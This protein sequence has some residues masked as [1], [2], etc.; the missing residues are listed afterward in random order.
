M[1]IP[2]GRER[3]LRGLFAMHHRTGAV[4]EKVAFIVVGF[5]ILDWRSLKKLAEWGY[6]CPAK[7]QTGGTFTVVAEE[8]IDLYLRTVYWGGHTDVYDGLAF[9]SFGDH[10][11]QAQTTSERQ[12]NTRLRPRRD[13]AG[14]LQVF[15]GRSRFD[16]DCLHVEEEPLL[17]DP[18]SRYSCLLLSSTPAPTRTADANAAR[19]TFHP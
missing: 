16:S 18:P 5:V 13:K 4:L 2:P 11:C 10:A 19:A 15:L 17:Q 1:H 14:D 12:F 6:I 7:Q 8:V 3:E 9:V